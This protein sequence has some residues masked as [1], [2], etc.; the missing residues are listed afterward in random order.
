MTHNEKLLNYNVFFQNTR[1]NF[2]SLHKLCNNISD[3]SYGYNVDPQDIKELLRHL[4]FNSYKY[5]ATKNIGFK[6]KLLIFIKKIYGNIFYMFLKLFLN[7][8]L[9]V[10]EKVLLLLINYLQIQ[11][12]LKQLKQEIK[13]LKNKI[14]AEDII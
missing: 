2:L 9:K 13:E 12:Q 5:H 6:T 11:Q 7:Q 1:S 14:R 4:Y 3:S 10:N 8:Q